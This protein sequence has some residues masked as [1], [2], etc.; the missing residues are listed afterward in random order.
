[1]TAFVERLPKEVL[2]GALQ[3]MRTQRA[4]LGY[5]VDI[6]RILAARLVQMATTSGDAELA[7]MLLDPDAGALVVGGDAG[8]ELGELATSR[9]GLNVVE[10]RTIGLLLP[11]ESPGLRDESADVLRGRDVGARLAARRTD[12]RS[13]RRA[14]WRPPTRGRTRR[15]RRAGSWSRLRRSTSRRPASRC[16]W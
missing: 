5:G 9:R 12:A 6:E 10:G 16:A 14:R 7:R 4:S 1:M 2:V 13:R 15:E 3:A 8:M 11:T